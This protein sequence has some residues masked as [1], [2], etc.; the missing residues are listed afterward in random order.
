MFDVRDGP[1]PKPFAPYALETDPGRRLG[2][3][4]GKVGDQHD[5]CF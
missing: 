5:S 1:N 4:S 3:L 2:L